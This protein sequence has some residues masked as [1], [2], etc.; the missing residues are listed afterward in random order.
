[1]QEGSEDFPGYQKPKGTATALQEEP[2][3]SC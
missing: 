1:M 3:D 2:S